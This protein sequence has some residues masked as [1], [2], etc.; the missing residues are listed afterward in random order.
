MACKFLSLLTQHLASRAGTRCV[1]T[2]ST[3]QLTRKRAI[4]R[5][6]QRVARERTKENI[7]YLERQIEEQK[8]QIKDQNLSL[9]LMKQRYSQL[10]SEMCAQGALM[11]LMLNATNPSNQ[12][13]DYSGLGVPNCMPQYIY[14]NIGSMRWV[15]SNDASEGIV[16]VKASG[17]DFTPDSFF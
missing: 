15:D 17:A 8:R 5:E 2:L 7:E 4:D 6:S 9:G 14:D 11:T 13:N 12:N 10:E 1:S 16:L 3:A